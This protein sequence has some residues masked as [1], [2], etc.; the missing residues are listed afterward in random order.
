M[1]VSLYAHQF[2]SELTRKLRPRFRLPPLRIPR[3]PDRRRPIYLPIT[4]LLSMSAHTIEAED[5]PPWK[6]ALWVQ[7][8]EV[9]MRGGT[10]PTE[11]Q[12][13]QGCLRYLSLFHH[14]AFSFLH[15]YTP[16]DYCTRYLG[17]M[18]PHECFTASRVGY[19][20]AAAVPARWWHRLA[21]VIL[22]VRVK[23][24]VCGI[25]GYHS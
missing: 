3:S 11:K 19:L 1:R 9:A 21:N 7:K 13:A 5:M 24:E 2:T 16:T 4:K 23:F 17:N 18:C 22:G 6:S 25:R 8:K 14:S 12:C 20:T 15:S 10:N